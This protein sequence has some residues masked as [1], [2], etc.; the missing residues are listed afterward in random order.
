[1]AFIRA[2]CSDCGDVELRSYDLSLRKCVDTQAATY[3]FR[4]PRCQMTEVRSADPDVFEVLV[5][6]GVGVAEWCLPAEL[7]EVKPGGQPFS[8]DDQ[9]DLNVALRGATDEEILKEAA[10][11]GGDE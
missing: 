4:C 6:A 11:C 2:T 9:I 7:S 1:M 5:S 8:V 10:A 3:S